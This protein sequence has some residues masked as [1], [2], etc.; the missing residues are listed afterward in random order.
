[1]PLFIFLN[2]YFY[3][4]REYNEEWK[5]SIPLVETCLV[6]HLLFLVITNNVNY[7]SLIAFDDP[8][9][10]LLCLVLWRLCSS[11]LLKHGVTVIFISAIVI[12]IFSF[13]L[14]TSNGSV[15]SIMRFLQFYPYFLLGYMMKGKMSII[16]QNKSIISILGICSLFIII[17]TSSRFQHLILFQRDG[18]NTLA[19][20]SGLNYII[21][22][23]YRYVILFSSLS[24]SA[25]MLL[26]TG[27]I[28][29]IK[30]VSRFGQ[31]TLFIYFGQTLLY[32]IVNRC[33]PNLY[34]SLF[35]SV[36]ALLF[37]TYLSTKHISKVAMNPISMLF[38]K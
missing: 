35:F 27:K 24:V 17:F 8:S 36:I 1:M 29:I 25:L 20:I 30:K 19:K 33:F 34:L 38:S 9:W 3:K 6:S 10:Y 4:V 26:L 37:L 15:F 5:K 14:F 28:D 32:P 13:L 21:T 18:I 22:F 11:I 7:H 16:N 31:H 23:F 2:G 12:E